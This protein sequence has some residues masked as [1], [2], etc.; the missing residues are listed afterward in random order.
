[1]NFYNYITK[2]KCFVS[3]VCHVQCRH[4]YIAAITYKYCDKFANKYILLLAY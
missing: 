1:M 2:M 3:K 4:T